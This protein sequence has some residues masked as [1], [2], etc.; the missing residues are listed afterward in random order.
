MLTTTIVP[1]DGD[2]RSEAIIPSAA[3]LAQSTGG[4]LVLLTVL[5]PDEAKAPSE[6][7]FVPRTQNTP[8]GRVVYVGPGDV[9]AAGPASAHVS[10]VR[11]GESAEDDGPAAGPRLGQNTLTAARLYLESVATPLREAGI[12]VDVQVVEGEPVRQIFD[13]V[14][15]ENADTVALA[16]HR[17]SALARAFGGSVTDEVVR[18]CPVPVLSMH[19]GE[20]ERAGEP[21]QKPSTLIVP[22]DGSELSETAVEPAFDLAE[23]LGANIV[24]IRSASGPE[25]MVWSTTEVPVPATAQVE[26]LDQAIEDVDDYL[27][28]FVESSRARNVTAEAKH[29]VGGASD[30][31]LEEA[32]SHSHSMIVMTTHGSSGFKRA[33]LG[34]V[35]DQVVRKSDRPVLV[36]GNGAS[37]GQE[38]S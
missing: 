4:R 28:K 17:S 23:Q 29:G 32:Q 24:F 38:D 5:D 16:T 21:V 13:A 8:A 11:G 36:V 35:T 7:R 37:S 20:N 6:D 9:T 12:D 15:R 25:A 22:L 34:S 33:L 26:M 10:D 19:A 30:L 1:L 3:G 2:T 18:T 14:E 27:Q 31:I